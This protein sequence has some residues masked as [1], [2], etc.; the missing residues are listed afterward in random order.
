[1]CCLQETHFKC[2]DTGKLKAERW[3]KMYDININQRIAGVAKLMPGKVG[4]K[5]KKIT[6]GWEGHYM[7]MLR[8][9]HQEDRGLR[10]WRG[11]KESAHQGRRH[12]RLEFSPWVGTISWKRKW[13]PTPAF[14]PGKSHGWRS[15]ADYSP[16][17]QR[18]GQD[19][20]IEQWQPGRHRIPN[21][22]A[23]NNSAAKSVRQN[24]VD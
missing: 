14:L 18:V 9:V 8:S 20:V 3:E 10:R 1:M 24:P 2:N 4:F 13:Q 22:D 7:M 11:A 21:L 5:A 23:V 12:R 19:L 17:S 16:W 6:R 15:L